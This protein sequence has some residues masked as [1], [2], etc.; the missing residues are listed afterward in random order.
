MT[1]QAPDGFWKRQR[2]K[3]VFDWINL[4][5]SLWPRLK[6]LVYYPLVFGSFGR[7]SILYRPTFL[8][9]PR[10]IHIGK[11]VTILPGARL[12]VVLVDRSRQPRLVIGDNVNLE[13][14]VH[15][16]CHHRVV[17]EANVS[18]TGFCSIVDTTHP[19]DGLA[20]D[21]KMGNLVVDDE[22]AVEIGRGTFI[23]MGARILP[24]VRI[25]QGAV[26]GANSVVTRDVPEFCVASGVPAVV[27]RQRRMLTASAVP[28]NSQ[29]ES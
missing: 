27:R 17:I 2:R 18:V 23:G 6:S 26:I 3:S 9:N 11:R 1:D 16:V 14:G 8:G 20:P 15:I 4:A 21:A 12:E 5:S 19:I 10:Y 29:Q 28:G 22:S 25:G 13:Q 24:N 7:G